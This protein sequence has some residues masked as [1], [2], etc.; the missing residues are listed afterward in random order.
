M[1]K[2][3]ELFK[4][5]QE[6]LSPQ[7]CESDSVVAWDTSS[8]FIQKSQHMQITFLSIK[9]QKSTYQATSW[10][11]PFLF[12]PSKQQTHH[13]LPG[14]PVSSMVLCSRAVQVCA[15][16]F[17]QQNPKT[18]HTSS[19]LAC[20]PLWCVAWSSAAQPVSSV[21]CSLQSITWK[22]SIDHAFPLFEWHSLTSRRDYRFRYRQ[23][24]TP[25][26]YADATLTG[27]FRP[28]SLTWHDTLKNVRSWEVFSDLMDVARSMHECWSAGWPVNWE[29]CLELKPG[30]H[31]LM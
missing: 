20:E 25:W 17:K 19:C 11:H 1:L 7:H 3:I 2:V 26:F 13:K 24:R 28:P 29:F 30:R 5:K 14:T 27:L 23:D 18:Q 12:L 31:E 16:Y 8:I 10:L 21:C 22:K 9:Q 15:P 4:I 6:I